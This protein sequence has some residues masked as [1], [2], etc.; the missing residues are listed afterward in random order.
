M[1]MMVTKIFLRSSGRKSS[2]KSLTTMNKKV[3]IFAL[4]IVLSIHIVFCQSELNHT[5]SISVIR[6]PEDYSIVQ[7]AINAASAG[8]IIIIDSG[9]YY[10]NIVI[11]KPISLIGKSKES[12]I[13]DGGGIGDVVCISSAEVK[14]SGFTIRNSGKNSTEETI[15]DAGVK[16]SKVKNCSISNCIIVDNYFGIY[17]TL[18]NNNVLENNTCFKNSGGGMLLFLSC[19]NNRLVNNT[20]MLN[21]GFGG[22]LLRESCNFNIIADNI[23]EWNSRW[24]QHGIKLLDFCN[25]NILENNTSVH[26]GDG[27]FLLISSNNLIINNILNSNLRAGM[28]IYI[29]CVN[30]TISNNT[31]NLNDGGGITLYFSSDNNTI[32][33]N[34]CSNNSQ[35]GILL[36]SCNNNTIINNTCSFNEVALEIRCSSSNKVFYNVLSMSYQ[37]VD[38]GVGG[39]PEP[40]QIEHMREFGIE[41]RNNSVGNWISW[42]NITRNKTGMSISCGRNQVHWNY[43]EGNEWGMAG[44]TPKEEV[45]VTYNW[46][47][48]ATGPFHSSE[49]PNGLGNEIHMSGENVL[50]KPWWIIRKTTSTSTTSTTTT[51][52][53]QAIPNYTSSMFIYSVVVVIIVTVLSV[54]LYL[55]R[56]REGV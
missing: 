43:I 33:S 34:L 51:S 28:Q 16:M 54:F 27:I 42:N 30:N 32:K 4:L 3:I 15:G 49:N 48:D 41:P 40:E 46:W 44:E 26:N 38:I 5:S 35:P 56:K 17:M 24:D 8:H 36:W 11:S 6:V 1:D 9:V 12:T 10:E 47:G 2:K 25:N 22:I 18:S 29:G 19:N 50:F 21:G 37:G 55:R 20:S 13:I 53:Q 45:N 39:E 7:E 52:I 23:C 31:C 14:V